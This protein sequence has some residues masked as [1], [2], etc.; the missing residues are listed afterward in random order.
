MY[1]L[2]VIIF[3][4]AGIIGLFEKLQPAKWH[5][6]HKLA[7]RSIGVIL[8]ITSFITL[9]VGLE[10]NDWSHGSDNWNDMQKFS[11][12]VTEK[13]AN[14]KSVSMHDGYL[15]ITMKEVSFHKNESDYAPDSVAM[16]LGFA[17]ESTL[18]KKGTI[19]YQ[20]ADGNNEG[21]AILYDH[22]SLMKA[23]SYDAVSENKDLLLSKSTAYR[24]SGGAYN[25][26]G[27]DDSL[28]L[29]SDNQPKPFDKFA[30]EHNL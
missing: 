3:A 7:K 16:A 27:F 20:N 9:S 21:F 8:I 12:H 18:A 25:N 15:L 26:T 14:I 2:F 24:L 4:T 28:P 17:K 5:G 22:S 10:S 6:K 19:I 23:P 30:E 1:F 29:N 11:K 13:D